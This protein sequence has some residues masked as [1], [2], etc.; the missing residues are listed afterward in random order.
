[1]VKVWS[2]TELAQRGH[3]LTKNSAAGRPG[4]RRSG[5]RLLWMAVAASL[6]LGVLL[7]AV[8]TYALR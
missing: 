3:E 4:P 5:S 1:M 8:L 6:V 2:F 7:A